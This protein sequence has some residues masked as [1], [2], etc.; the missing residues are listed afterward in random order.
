M[1]A[2]F[3]KKDGGGRA[4]GS[5]DKWTAGRPA[6]LFTGNGKQRAHCGGGRGGHLSVP[7][8]GRAGGGTA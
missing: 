5:G 8:A 1:A 4:D 2:I 3:V 6:K 7:P